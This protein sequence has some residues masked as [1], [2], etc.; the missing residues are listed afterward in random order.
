MYASFVDLE[1]TFAR[2]PCKVLWWS[3]REL[4][5]RAQSSVSLRQCTVMYSNPVYR[6]MALLVN[7]SKWWLVYI[8]VPYWVHSCSL[9][10]W[11]PYQACLWSVVYH[12]VHPTPFCWGEGVEPPTKFSK[13]EDLTGT[14]L[15][16]GVAGKEGMT[17][18]VSSPFGIRGGWFL[19]HQPSRGATAKL[20]EPGWGHIHGGIRF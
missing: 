3:L 8:R 7:L 2:V 6:W 11:K 15:L 17:I 10:W 20:Q 19:C 13:R 14:Q 1:K 5:V 4:G 12:S 16:E 9:L 18:T